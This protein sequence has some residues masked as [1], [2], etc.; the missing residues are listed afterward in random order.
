MTQSPTIHVTALPKAS[1]QKIHIT[2]AP[3]DPATPFTL[4]D[5]MREELENT[6][7]ALNAGTS[8][9]LNDGTREM[10]DWGLFA[11]KLQRVLE[12][13]DF[14]LI[15]NTPQAIGFEF[16]EVREADVEPFA[17]LVHQAVSHTVEI[18]PQVTVE[19][20]RL[21]S[22]QDTILVNKPAPARPKAPD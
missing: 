18:E 8:P 21:V 15:E 4:I 11:Q 9:L 6:I 17:Q 2:V 5:C 3:H 10:K 20:F 1:L 13:M 12:D 7:R 16:R 22:E 19:R 14:A